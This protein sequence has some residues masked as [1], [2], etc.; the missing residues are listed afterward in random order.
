[1]GMENIEKK[2]AAR[3]GRPPKS[4]AETSKTESINTFTSTTT[5]TVEKPVQQ[6]MAIPE[7][8]RVEYENYGIKRSG[9]KRRGVFTFAVV[10]V[11]LAL[12]ILVANLLLDNA[13]FALFKSS[14]AEGETVALEGITFWGIEVDQFENKSAALTR[15]REII[16]QGGAGYVMG[17]EGQPYRVLCCVYCSK[18]ESDAEWSTID[19]NA[20]PNARVREW[21]IEAREVTINCCHDREAFVS[22]TNSFRENFGEMCNRMVDYKEKK[23]TAKEISGWALFTYNS[24][25]QQV[26]EF[27]KIQ[28]NAK[29]VVYAKT[30]LQVNKQLL[31]IYQLAYEGD[32]SNYLSVLKSA[33][34]GVAFSYAELLSM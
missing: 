13:I 20:M 27:S 29:S 4:A 5:S 32:S 28:E 12:A 11:I 18:A 10:G 6:Q 17:E 33:M 25:Q 7:A 9:K 8:P 30:L 14:A 31:A 24:L 21:K 15:S 19:A 3:R 1:M 16:K 34:C 23:T 26:V 22:L 2:P